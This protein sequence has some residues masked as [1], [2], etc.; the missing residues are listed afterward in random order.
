MIKYLIVFLINFCFLFS[1]KAENLPDWYKDTENTKLYIYGL[2]K[3]NNL[4][5]AIKVA[6]NNIKENFLK[7]SENSKI[8]INLLNFSNYEIEKQENI[9]NINYILLVIRRNELLGLQLQ[10][11]NEIVLNIENLYNFLDK[12]NDLVKLTKFEEIQK[13]INEMNNKI[14]IIKLIDNKFNDNKYN[15]LRKRIENKYINL[16]NNMDIKIEIEQ[17]RAKS[18]LKYIIYNIRKNN[19]IKINDKSNN[20]LR[21]SYKIKMLNVENNYN[22]N[23][24][25]YTKIFDKDG[26]LMNYNSFNYSFSSNNSFT[27]AIETIMENFKE[28]LKSGK[29]KIIDFAIKNKYNHLLM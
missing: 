4:E 10:Q 21:L 23:I 13:F 3:G 19:F 28:D 24:L 12:K 9:N 8:D 7:K 14:E 20:T 1:V 5:K 16:L 17:K 15:L 18:L 22:V 6:L 2:G 27:D 26:N 11:L 29:I 25:F